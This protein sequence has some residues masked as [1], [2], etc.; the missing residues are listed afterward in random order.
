[1][2]TLRLVKF[3]PAQNIASRYW[4]Q[5]GFRRNDQ[6]QISALAPDQQAV[7]AG[8]M[9]WAE[10]KLPEGFTVLESV[11]LRREADVPTEWSTP[12]APEEQPQPTAFGPSFVASITGH[13]PLGQQSV[14]IHSDQSPAFLALAALWEQ[15]SQ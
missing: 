15:F 5:D 7:V 8:A 14:E 4:E 11:E 10:S 3:S 12:A 9:A 2:K 13:G 6:L 1:M